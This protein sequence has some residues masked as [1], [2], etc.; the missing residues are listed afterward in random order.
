[1]DPGSPYAHLDAEETAFWYSYMKVL[2]RV[3]YEMNRQL[4][5]DSG[6]SLSDFDVL[7]ALTSGPDDRL[8]LTQLAERIGWERTRASHH[9]R[10]MATRGLVTVAPSPTDGRATDVT[11]TSA[12]RA[13]LRAASAGHTEL[14]RTM[15]FGGVEPEAAEQLTTTL[16]RIY[17]NLLA[18]SSSP[19]RVDKP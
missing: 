17:E 7:L 13:T 15:F 5:A 14:I 1:V 12:G 19:G 8:Q 10:R 11:L 2:L 4:R 6:I 18:H 9:A 3:R 16:S